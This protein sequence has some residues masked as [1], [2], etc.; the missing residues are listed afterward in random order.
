MQQPDH[1]SKFQPGCFVNV[2]APFLCS[3]GYPF[4]HRL[5]IAYLQDYKPTGG[6]TENEKETRDPP[7]FSI[8]IE[9]LWR[10]NHATH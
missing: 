6:V 4:V 1:F 8:V 10:N 3:S 5:H 2:F 7:G 9:L